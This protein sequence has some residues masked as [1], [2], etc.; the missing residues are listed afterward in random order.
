MDCVKCEGESRVVNSRKFADM[1]RRRRECLECR[2]RWTTEEF[3]KAG[4]SAKAKVTLPSYDPIQN[5]IG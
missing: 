3:R 1:V 2:E 4:S 5:I